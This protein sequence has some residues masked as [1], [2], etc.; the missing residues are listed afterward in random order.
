MHPFP[1]VVTAWLEEE[2]VVRHRHLAWAK[3]TRFILISFGRN[4]A[5]RRKSWTA[6]SYA[7]APVEGEFPEDHRGRFL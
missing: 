4:L 7:S 5:R 1:S 3:W 2:V 6:E